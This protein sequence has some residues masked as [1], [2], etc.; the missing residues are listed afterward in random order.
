MIEQLISTTQYEDALKRL[1]TGAKAF[2]T[3]CYATPKQ[4]GEWAESGVLSSLSTAGALLLLRSSHHVT[5]LLHIAADRQS[6]SEALL[7]LAEL[8][9][10]K[11]IVVDLVGKPTDVEQ[12]TDIYSSR[13]FSS[14]K[15][16]IRM[17]RFGA[18]NSA[19]PSPVIRVHR[20][21]WVEATKVQAFLEPLLDPLAEQI[22]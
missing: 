16:L 22:P 17:V 10:A 9:L 12:I 20:A 2:T 7:V 5:H 21:T 18:A 1:K 4:I 14:Y 11:P 8:T 3:S 13:G 15:E 6:L 19:L